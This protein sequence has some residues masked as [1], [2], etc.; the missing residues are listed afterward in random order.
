MY[1]NDNNIQGFGNDAY[2][3]ILTHGNETIATLPDPD[4]FEESSFAGGHTGYLYG[5]SIPSQSSGTYKFGGRSWYFLV[6]GSSSYINF[7]TSGNSDWDFSDTDYTID[8]WMYFNRPEEL[9]EISTYTTICGIYYDTS[10]YNMLALDSDATI[11]NLVYQIKESDTSRL[12]LSYDIS[13]Y[14]GEFI[15]IAI[16]REANEYYMF[17]NGESADKDTYGGT[18]V[19]INRPFMIG[20]MATNT[21]NITQYFIDEFRLSKGIARWNRDFIVPNREY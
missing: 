3:V 19:F 9:T 6:S 12:S 16:V 21:V 15:H 2:C 20:D 18:L 4:T 11:T 8:F 1:N 13:E 7:G 10:N 17:V 5:T 14:S